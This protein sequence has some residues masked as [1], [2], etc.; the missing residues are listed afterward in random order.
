MDLAMVSFTKIYC[1]KCQNY[2]NEINHYQQINKN[3]CIEF[4]RKDVEL[5]NLYANLR[6][7]IKEFNSCQDEKKLVQKEFKTLKNEHKSLLKDHQITKYTILSNVENKLK[8]SCKEV[9]SLKMKLR[10]MESQK[11]E[12]EKHQEKMVDKL[13]KQF[14]P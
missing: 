7:Y 13:G 6:S 5:D 4:Q 3:L 8:D 14:N 9:E 12:I 2:E 1:F 11:V 10:I